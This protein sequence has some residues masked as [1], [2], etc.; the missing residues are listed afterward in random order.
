MRTAH[1]WIVFVLDSRFGDTRRVLTGI[2]SGI[3]G[4]VIKRLA[5]RDQKD[6]WKIAIHNF[7]ASL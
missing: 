1:F 5:C 7:A 6:D 3:G 4:P 2:V